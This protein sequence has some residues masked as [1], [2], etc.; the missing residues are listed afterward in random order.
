M[1]SNFASQTLTLRQ[2]LRV[3]PCWLQ[4]RNDICKEMQCESPSGIQNGAEHL[5]AIPGNRSCEAHAKS[6]YA[7]WLSMS[8]TIIMRSTIS[9]FIMHPPYSRL[10]KFLA[11]QSIFGS[12]GKAGKRLSRS[13]GVRR[14][15]D[16]PINFNSQP[17][18]NCPMHNAHQRL[19]LGHES[20]IS[21]RQV[22]PINSRVTGQHLPQRCR[23][24]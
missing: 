18:Q 4:T 16:I 17:L 23:R 2:H 22:F 24:R 7:G 6:A 8:S 11:L 10:S 3:L 21:Q 15:H 13:G 14:N 9:Y 19:M 12:S 1:R 5:A 20:L